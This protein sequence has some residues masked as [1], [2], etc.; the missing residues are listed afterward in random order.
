[1]QLFQNKVKSQE[2]SY[3]ARKAS[4]VHH[5]EGIRMRIYSTLRAVT[6]TSAFCFFA[7]LL[8]VDN[9]FAAEEESRFAIPSTNEGLPGEGPIRRYEWFQNLWESRRSSWIE[10]IEIDQGAVVFLGDSIIQGWGEGLDAAFPGMK[11]ANRG[12]SGDTSRGVLIRLEEDVFAANP[13]AVVL[14]IGTNDLE[15]GAAPEVIANNVQLILEAISKFNP[16][17]PIIF[18]DVM[19]SSSQMSRPTEQIQA[20]NALYRNILQN[21]PQATR[22]DTFS[23]FDNGKG[24]ASLNEFPDLLHPNE[25]G[26]AKWAEALRPVLR[27]LELMM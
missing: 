7:V 12:I 15:E 10:S 24:N 5:S 2:I 9:G 16:E 17:M 27:R 25:L 23:L 22:L 20:V 21:Y 3:Y 6:L 19:P 13:S 1:M 4:H 14:L 18:C 11:V 8:P 26:Y